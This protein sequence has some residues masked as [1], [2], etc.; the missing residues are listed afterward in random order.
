MKTMLNTKEIKPGMLVNIHEHDIYTGKV[1]I[2][3]CA[4]AIELLTEG[5][6]AGTWY[7]Y[8]FG[9]GCGGGWKSEELHPVA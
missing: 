1:V 4:R 3:K 2:K 8:L 9:V 5:A 7:I 6:N